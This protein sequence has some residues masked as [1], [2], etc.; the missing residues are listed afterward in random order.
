MNRISIRNAD[1][2]IDTDVKAEH[3]WN[4]CRE[5]TFVMDESNHDKMMTA[6]GTNTQIDFHVDGSAIFIFNDLLCHKHAIAGKIIITFTED[7]DL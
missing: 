6:I 7:F 4:R 1:R 5:I 3:F 2:T